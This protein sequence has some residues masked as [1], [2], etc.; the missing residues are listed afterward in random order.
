MLTRIHMSRPLTGVL[1]TQVAVICSLLV[2]GCASSRNQT[3]LGEGTGDPFQQ[4]PASPGPGTTTPADVPGSGQMVLPEQQ[5]TQYRGPLGFSF[6]GQP[7]YRMPPAYQGNTQYR[8]STD[9]HGGAMPRGLQP[10]RPTTPLQPTPDN[11]QSLNRSPIELGLPQPEGDSPA[12]ESGPQLGTPRTYKET[13]PIYPDLEPSQADPGAEETIRRR[14]ESESL[15]APSPST[16]PDGLV[17][18]AEPTTDPARRP[19]EL[20]V[21]DPQR[22]LLA[23]AAKFE[24]VIRNTSSEAVDEVVIV[25]EFDEGLMFPEMADRALRQRLGTLGAAESRTIDLALTADQLGQQCVTFSLSAGGRDTAIEERCVEVVDPSTGVSR[26]DGGVK[27]ELVGP[28][29][30]NAG[31]RLECVMIVE[32]LTGRDVSGIV[33]AVNYD[34]ALIP[35]EASAGARRDAGTL[36]WDLG[37]LRVDERVQ[38]QVEFGCPTPAEH[39]CIDAAVS[40]RDLPVQ[41][42]E[43]CTVIRPRPTLDVSVADA[44]DPVPVGETTTYLVTITNRGFDTIS[45][46]RL[47]AEVS[48]GLEILAQ[49]A[50][51]A[52]VAFDGPQ[53]AT[54]QSAT[55]AVAGS[56]EPDES[57]QIR[58][59]ARATSIGVAGIRVLATEL[60][61]GRRVEV[62]EPT[63]VTPPLLQLPSFEDIAGSQ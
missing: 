25:C 4:F 41:R 10:A 8:S 61:T 31:G 22:V 44:R 13:V 52:E 58:I 28:R 27:V 33:A 18:P 54:L 37:M 34:L 47:D 3:Y 36:E 48:G 39:V 12:G 60:A 42:Q 30:R 16:V 46:M 55:Y 56:I 43:L 45:D 7:R 40:G 49:E 15:G 11:S 23:E 63:I 29:S 6:Y 51:L 5:I 35:R 57:R 32:N 50:E 17:L 62:D 24:V 2:V 19:L 1:C 53:P 38:I 59:D 26:P 14:L 21:S 20:V 9:F